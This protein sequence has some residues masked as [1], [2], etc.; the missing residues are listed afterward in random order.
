MIKWT[1]FSFEKKTREKE[2]Y[3]FSEDLQKYMLINNKYVI[4]FYVSRNRDL[5]SFYN[6]VKKKKE[7]WYLDTNNT[8]RS[9]VQYD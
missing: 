8:F 1:F 3:L 6:H 7:K 4:A 2:R 9:L 5:I